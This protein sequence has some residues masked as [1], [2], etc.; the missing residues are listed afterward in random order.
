[1]GRFVVAEI[2][3]FV[4]SFSSF[5]SFASLSEDFSSAE[6]VA[7]VTPD[8]EAVVEAAAGVFGMPEMVGAGSS[9]PSAAF[10]ESCLAKSDACHHSKNLRAKIE[11]GRRILRLESKRGYTVCVNVL[12]LNS[13]C[14]VDGFAPG[15]VGAGAA[16]A[17]MA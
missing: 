8:L 7:N 5:S 17:A 2:G 12:G 1:M 9:S 10:R 14:E 16:A 4:F 6:G 11:V 13:D 15:K 3:G